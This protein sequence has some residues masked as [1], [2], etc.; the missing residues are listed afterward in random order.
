MNEGEF[1]GETCALSIALKNRQALGIVGGILRLDGRPIAV[2]L[3]SESYK[4]TFTVHFE[5]ADASVPG[6]YQM[7]NQQFA[8]N[9]FGKYTYID[10]EEDLGLEGLRKSKLSYYPEFI[11]ENYNAV[12]RE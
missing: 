4:D 8:L 12:P 11:T 6:A 1:L 3:G 9:N 5:K 10:R 7:I 2:T